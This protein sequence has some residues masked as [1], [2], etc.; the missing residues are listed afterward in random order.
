MRF[1]TGLLSK[2]LFLNMETQSQCSYSNYSMLREIHEMIY[3]QAFR[4]CVIRSLYIAIDYCAI[5]RREKKQFNC[6]L[7]LI[8]GIGA[9]Y[10]SLRNVKTLQNL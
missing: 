2:Q 4:K 7:I 5:V 1:V 10:E 3:L 6:F 8:Y 9:K